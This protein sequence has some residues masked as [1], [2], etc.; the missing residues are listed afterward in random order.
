MVGRVEKARRD[1][2]IEA[3]FRATL[4]TTDGETVYG[5]RYSSDKASKTLYHSEG[6]TSIRTVGG[7]EEPFPADGRI[8]VSEPLELE[9]RE[10][11]WVEVPEWSLVTLRAGREPSITGFEP[12]A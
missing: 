11:H 12:V 5:V 8:L 10:Q 3:P 7:H 2:G 6:I 4:A 1:H 9:Y